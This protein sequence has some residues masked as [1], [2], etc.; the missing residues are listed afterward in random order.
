MKPPFHWN[1]AEQAAEEMQHRPGARRTLL[2]LA[3][4]P[5]LPAKTI[6]QLAGRRGGASVYRT[7]EYLGGAGLVAA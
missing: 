1:D 4:L 6:Q 5:L 7:L 2:L 3:R